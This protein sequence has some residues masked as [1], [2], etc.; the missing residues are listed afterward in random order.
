MCNRTNKSSSSS[1]LMCIVHPQNSHRTV[2]NSNDKQAQFFSVTLCL[3]VTLTALPLCCAA[4]TPADDADRASILSGIHAVTEPGG[5][6]GDL[7]VFGDRAFTLIAGKMGKVNV[8]VF[9]AAHFGSG[10]VVVGGHESF[11]GG[12]A[13]L[14]ADN[15]TFAVNRCNWLCNKKREFVLN[16]WVSRQ[17]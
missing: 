16:W 1:I 3:Y 6:P 5:L 4:A 9:A 2:E 15:K 13:L 10:R 12:A 7:I 14:N 17:N 11:F 8:P